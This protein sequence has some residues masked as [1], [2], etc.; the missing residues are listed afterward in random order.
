MVDSISLAIGVVVGTLLEKHS[1]RF[2]VRYESD[3]IS[4]LCAVSDIY[5]S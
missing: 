4:G 5:G 1:L 2:K 3:K